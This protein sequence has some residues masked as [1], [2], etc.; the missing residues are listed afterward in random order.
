MR[1]TYNTVS[2]RKHKVSKAEVDDVYA[3]GVDFDLGPSKAGNDRIMIVGF[4]AMGR[5]LE[6]GIEY[7]PNDHEHIFHAADATKP[8]QLLFEKRKR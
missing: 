7:F 1:T 4:A 6:I 8:Y 5:L 3:T 2:L